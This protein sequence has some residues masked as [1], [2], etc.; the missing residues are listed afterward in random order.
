LRKAGVS[1]ELTELKAQKEMLV[2]AQAEKGLTTGTKASFSDVKNMVQKIK[3]NQ[4]M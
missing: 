4:L 3:I 1:R 2:A